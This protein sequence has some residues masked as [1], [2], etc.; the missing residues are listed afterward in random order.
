MVRAAGFE[1]CSFVTTL[2]EV[3]NRDS[4]V[5]QASVQHLANIRHY[6]N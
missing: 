5:R 6:L 4:L 3:S 1:G 2:L